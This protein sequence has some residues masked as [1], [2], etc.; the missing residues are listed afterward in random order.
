MDDG[1]RTHDDRNHNPGLYQ[2]SYAHHCAT[3][4]GVALVKTYPA[5]GYGAPGR[6]RTCNPRLR[7]PMLYPVELRAHRCRPPVRVPAARKFGRG[8]RIRTADPLLPKQMRYQTAP[9]PAS[10]PRLA[11]AAAPHPALASSDENANSTEA[12]TRRQF[13]DSSCCCCGC[14]R[15]S[16]PLR[17]P[18]TTP[19]G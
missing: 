4:L 13:P 6:T 19:P 8:R 3:L 12:H 17:H 5:F 11:P 2:L 1:T 16:A 10:L 15:Q 7:R 9:C 14:V 18:E